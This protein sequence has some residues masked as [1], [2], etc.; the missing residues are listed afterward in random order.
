MGPFETLAEVDL[1]VQDTAQRGLSRVRTGA[2]VCRRNS[3]FR[4]WGATKRA[5]GSESTDAKTLFWRLSAIRVLLCR[6]LSLF[7]QQPCDTGKGGQDVPIVQMRKVRFTESKSLA[8]SPSEAA[9]SSHN[10]KPNLN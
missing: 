4:S 6:R 5:R 1:M 7:S 8:W 3:L 9:I 2:P 10:R